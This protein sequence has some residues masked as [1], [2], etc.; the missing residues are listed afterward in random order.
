MIRTAGTVVHAHVAIDWL[1]GD[2]ARFV[3]VAICDLFEQ[4]LVP[5]GCHSELVE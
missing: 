2:S 4:A 1:D 3:L 5:R